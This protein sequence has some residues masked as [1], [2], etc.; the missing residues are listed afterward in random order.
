MSRI[1]TLVLL[2]FLLAVTAVVFSACKPAG[3]SGAHIRYKKDFLLQLRD[4]THDWIS[5]TNIPAEIIKHNTSSRFGQKRK[6]GKRGGTRLKLRRRNA[7]VPLPTI[8][9]ANVRSLKRK[10]D[11][12]RANT[13]YL[14]EYREACILAFT[15][16]WL[17]NGVSDSEVCPEGFSII[18]LDR[19][20]E[21]TGK[22]QGGGVCF[23][24]NDRWCRTTVIRKK[25]CTPDIELLSMSL[26]PSYLP[27]EFPQLF[28]TIVYIHPRAN[29]DKAADVIYNINQEFDEISPDAPK[30]VM[31]DF[32]NCTLK[33][34]L[35]T[36][37]QYVTCS[38]RNNKVIDLCY[39]SIP[40]AY[41]SCA[42]APLG[43][44]DHNTI[45]LTPTYKQVLKRVKPT[46][47]QTQVWQEDSVETLKGCF[48]STSWSTFED[49]AADLHELTEVISGYIDFCVETVIPKKTSRVYPNNK[50]WVTKELKGVLN[51]KKKDFCFGEPT[52]HKGSTEKSQ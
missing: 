41:S 18:R 10:A 46:V 5:D 25:I 45:L 38:T 15:E 20:S 9:L 32:N 30:F 24:I 27:R 14:Y 35:P 51:E 19:C 23:M 3:E 17:N 1:W 52:G 29:T 21:T 6:R 44:S 12:L 34:A 2:L 47:K 26:R 49:S 40:K 33:R 7:K 31:G 37:S 8:I 36:Y 39:G 42:K 28:L 48:E 22:E 11:E 16:T 43:S 13:R 4:R 50:P